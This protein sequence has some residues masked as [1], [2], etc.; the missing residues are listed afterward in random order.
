MRPNEKDFDHNLIPED[1]LGILRIKVNKSHRKESDW[2]VI[3][4][5]LNTY[6]IVTV[7]PM[8]RIPGIWVIDHVLCRNGNLVV[9]TN[10]SDCQEYV[11]AIAKTTGAKDIYFT[12]GS[13]GFEEVV[14]IADRERMELHLDPK[15]ERNHKFIRY[16]WQ[17]KKLA[18]TMNI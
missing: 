4:E 5:I 10:A 6:R 18:V 8:A 1:K 11:K 13:I 3:K 9:F 16:K 14:G 2:D 12:M 7:E 15:D 17:D